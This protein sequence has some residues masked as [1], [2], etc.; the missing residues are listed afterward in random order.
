[1]DPAYGAQFAICD[2]GERHPYGGS[3]NGHNHG[4]RSLPGTIEILLID[5]PRSF[6]GDRGDSGA[7]GHHLADEGRW[8]VAAE[9][10]PMY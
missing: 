3:F 6:T 1:M 10:C 4:R 2:Q 7:T 8:W 5:R 9:E